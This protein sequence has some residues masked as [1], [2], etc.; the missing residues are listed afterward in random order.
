MATFVTLKEIRKCWN[1]PELNGMDKAQ[2]CAA[3]LPDSFDCTCS[4]QPE[5]YTHLCM[6]P[7]TMSK[8]LNGNQHDKDSNY[9]A[10]S[11][12]T[13]S[14]MD[15]IR[16][17]RAIIYQDEKRK[18]YTRKSMLEKLERWVNQTIPKMD[19]SH[20]LFTKLRLVNMKELSSSDQGYFKPLVDCI[21]TLRKMN[22]S[23]SLA[24]ALFLIILT[25]IFRQ[26]MA[27]LPELYSPQVIEDM[28]TT[29]S[30]ELGTE[31]TD[32]GYMG[33]YSIYVYRTATNR[34]FEDGV[35]SLKSDP[36]GG[37]KAKL[38]IIATDDSPD[39]GY[40]PLRY[41]YEG[42]AMY[43][44]RDKMVYIPMKDQFNSIGVL[45]FHYERFITGPM[46]YRTALFLSSAARTKYPQVRRA[47][48]CARNLEP[49]EI[50][51]VQGV[52]KAGGQQIVLTDRQ[53]E[54]FCS[55]FRDYPWM[56]EF[57]QVFLPFIRSHVCYCLD[58]GEI[59]ANSMSRLD[60]LDRMRMMLALKS[61]MSW[62]SYNRLD[63]S[64]PSDLHKIMK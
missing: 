29:A 54:D 46:Y 47:A 31:F 4:A 18:C 8:F 36:N 43:S 60:E 14:L 22:T 20:A 57:K 21:D 41:L 13:R 39:S 40:P 51:Y 3:I 24:Y 64:E 63:T 33:D 27:S 42:K 58:E 55:V 7:R 17:D 59:L 35:L 10:H 52:L 53:L 5:L 48:I 62:K 16:Y 15:Q 23:R 26:S 32:P 28:S 50:A 9:F 34:M 25:A 56:E 6:P 2:F 38:S 11:G 45:V 44:D 61:M 19:G 12:L 37:C 49:R 1:H 30:S